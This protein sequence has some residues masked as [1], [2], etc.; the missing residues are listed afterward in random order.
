MASSRPAAA[1]DPPEELVRRAARG[2]VAAFARIVRLH[3]E[4]MTQVAFVVVGDLAAAAGAAD[5]AWLGAW[6]GLR[7]KRTPKG[8]GPWLSSLAAAEAVN[9]ARR[10]ADRA[11]TAVLPFGHAAAEL[12]P[13]GH[14]AAA[15][16][17]LLPVGHAALG[18]DAL[19]PHGPPTGAPADDGLARALARL[20]PD[21]RALLALRN[22]AGLSIIEL[23][24]TRRRSR[25]PVRVRLE[26]LSADVGHR[27]APPPDP[28]ELDRELE[29]RL[30]AYAHVPVGQVDADAVARRARS[31]EELERT[32][33]VSVAISA[34]V[35]V[36][37]A[38]H[39]YLARLIFGH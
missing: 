7:R 20:G 19:T 24:E 35:G 33:V 15:S 27:L 11:A 12:L 9:V 1:Q 21:D 25:P 28:A 38:V 17:A 31:E 36:L 2:D 4:D 5:A 10:S 26:R 30:R 8:L 23:A 18:P 37:V 13:V 6:H 29:R 22:V 16:A 34:V 39:P 3:N 32:R 14:A